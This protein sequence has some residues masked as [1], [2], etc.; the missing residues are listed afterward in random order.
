MQQLGK[1]QMIQTAAK[2]KQAMQAI[3]TAANPQAAMNMMLMNNP[4]MKQVMEIVNQYGG[5]SMAAFRE[6]AK[7]MGVDPEEILGMIK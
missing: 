4:N 2:I 6:T 5:D 7:Q 1:N 3:K